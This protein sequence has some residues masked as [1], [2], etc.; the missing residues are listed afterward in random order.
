MRTTRLKYTIVAFLVLVTSTLAPDNTEYVIFPKSNLESE[1]LVG[2]QNTIE[3]LAGG[4]SRVYASVRRG[5][6]DPEFW[7]TR[8]PEADVRA[9]EAMENVI[10]S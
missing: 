8:L 9:L 7:V 2:L 4:P 5:S 10:T 1:E 3:T 6:S